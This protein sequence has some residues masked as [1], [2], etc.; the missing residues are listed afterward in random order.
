MASI[1]T[2]DLNLQASKKNNTHNFSLRFSFSMIRPA[3]NKDHSKLIEVWELSVRATH[4]FLPEDY[5]LEIKTLMPSFFTQVPHV[6]L[7]ETANEEIA[8]F[9]GVAEDKIEM[10]FIH[11]DYR[12]KGIGSQMVDF[13]ISELKADKVDVNEQNHQAVGF[14]KKKRFVQIGYQEKDG[15]GRVFPIL[16]MQL[17][18]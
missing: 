15:L 7:W 1:F 9:A 18:N 8:G 10:L 4:D 12:G 16:Q 2:Q 6:F 13:C 17:E 5:L 11:P 14:Y 3:T